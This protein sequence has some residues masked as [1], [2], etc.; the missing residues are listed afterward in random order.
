MERTPLLP[1]PQ[2]L[3]SPMLPNSKYDYLRQGHEEPEKRVHFHA[4]KKRQWQDEEGTF[5]I[6]SFVDVSLMSE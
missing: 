1:S 6:K 5:P 3:S 2:L 4:D